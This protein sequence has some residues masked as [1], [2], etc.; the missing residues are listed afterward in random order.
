MEVLDAGT[1]D[2]ATSYTTRVME[3]PAASEPRSRLSKWLREPLLQFILIGVV[4]FGVWRLVNPA[5]DMR[6]PSNRIVVSEDDL[7]Q[8][9][10]VWIAQGRPPPTP[11]Q[12][13]S[14]IETRVRE[15]TV[16][17]H[18]VPPV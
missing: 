13:Q 12:M 6:G 16:K 10:L 3:P 7:R 1:R 18:G 15:D 2:D 17:R 9:A 4:L 11:Q 8:M 14:L 5:A